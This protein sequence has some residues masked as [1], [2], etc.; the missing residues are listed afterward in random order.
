MKRIQLLN[1]LQIII[2]VFLASCKEDVEPS[3][4]ETL[5]VKAGEDQEVIVHTEVLLNG[6]AE[7]KGGN[8][9]YLWT[10]KTKPEGSEATLL[11]YANLAANF[12]P[13]L[14]GIYVL[15]LRVTK[16]LLEA[17]DEVTILVKLDDGSSPGGSEFFIK[18]DINEDTTWEDRFEDPAILDYVVTK[19]IAVNA[20]LT[21]RPGVVV[22][23]EEAAGLKVNGVIDAKGESQNRVVF[24]GKEAVRG[25]W[26]GILINSNSNENNLEN[27]LISFG[28][29]TEF[30]EFPGV[31]AN[32]IM[33][34]S[35]QPT[36][37]RLLNSSMQSSKSYG[38]YLGP[39]SKFNQFENNS[40]SYNEGAAAHVPAH[41][42]HMLNFHS[43][44]KDNNGY[45]G[46][47][48]GGVLN[49]PNPVTWPGF[50]DKGKYL[51]AEDFL[52]QSG[53]VIMPGAG[54][55]VKANKM[56][57]I[58]GAGYLKAIGSEASK[59]DFTAL[60]KSGNQ[61]WKGIHFKSQSIEN[62]L[63]NVNISYAGSGTFDGIDQKTNIAVSGRLIVKMSN[64]SYSGGYGVYATN[65][66][67]VNSDI[68]S[69][70]IF[71]ST[72]AGVVFPEVLANPSP[73][74][75]SGIWVDQWSFNQ[76]LYH[77][78]ENFYNRETGQW[79]GGAEYPWDPKP[80][81]GFG[82]SFSENGKFSWMIVDRPLYDPFCPSYSAEFIT[83]TYGFDTNT[84]HLNQEYWRSKFY[85]SCDQDSNYDG[86]IETGVIDLRYEIQKII[87]PV[88]GIAYW[89]LKF[90]NPDNSTFSYFKL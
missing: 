61:N 86:N 48:I 5:I 77:L 88:S 44:F 83:G 65:V 50:N 54:F 82:I 23:F 85:L 41:Q 16:E 56:I 13:D 33:A 24:T 73:P 38:I 71:A 34:N 8:L 78:D 69:S 52:V 28:G 60:I 15:N 37:L 1:Y 27:V 11:N 30:S 80:N 46:V 39:N 2:L 67:N 43:S 14:P 87:H 74:S 51:V 31:K 59:I 63:N 12:I 35:T 64:I 10:F 32:L 4:P 55:E 22:H 20:K 47:E 45:D 49:L 68:A 81:G 75:L 36:R 42:V 57:E 90:I 3:I 40:F 17:E 79:F 72:P 76:K 7:G 66:E 84:V 9:H 53:L 89:E 62:V 29:G 6:E 70:N 21:V 25:Y 58:S 18:E 26:K 19:E